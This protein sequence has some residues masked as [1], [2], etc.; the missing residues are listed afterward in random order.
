[1]SDNPYR[2]LPSL[3]AL[4]ARP[5]VAALISEFGRESVR[6]EARALLETIRAEIREGSPPPDSDT[7]AARLQ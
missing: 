5:E 1:M 4:L 7:I 3:D 6:D 2:H